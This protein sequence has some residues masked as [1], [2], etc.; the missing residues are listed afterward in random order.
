[1]DALVFNYLLEGTIYAVVG[2]GAYVVERIRSK[3]E[4]KKDSKLA[5]IVKPIEVK[6]D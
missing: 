3:R 1:M 6:R 2:T 5:E 4:S